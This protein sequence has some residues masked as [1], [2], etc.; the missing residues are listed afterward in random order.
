MLLNTGRVLSQYNVGAPT[1]RTANTRWHDE[2]R[3]EIHPA[4]AET[5][6]IAGHLQRF[7]E[8]RMRRQIVAHAE[9]GGEGLSEIVREAIEANRDTLAPSRGF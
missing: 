9:H 4:D 8:P 6:G 2:D 1:R 5:R 7:W 3:L